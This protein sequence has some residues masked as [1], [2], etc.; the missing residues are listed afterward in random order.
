MNYLLGLSAA[1]SVH[2]CH[3]ASCCSQLSAL[4][5][6]AHPLL[7]LPSVAPFCI[8]A[9][10]HPLLFACSSS[11][12]S[13]LPC[14]HTCVCMQRHQQHA[15]PLFMAAVAVVGVAVARI[16]AVAVVAV[17]VVRVGVAPARVVAGVVMAHVV[18]A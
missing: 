14:S 11:A 10:T 8:P 16:N 9:I 4:C 2:A 15:C 7:P 18:M 6:H 5:M 13:T 1:P 3:P 12:H 17:R